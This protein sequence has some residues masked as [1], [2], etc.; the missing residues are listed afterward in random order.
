MTG[1]EEALP[2]YLT[3]H[4]TADLLRTTRKAIYVMIQRRQLPGITHIGRRVLLRSADV[5]EWLDQSRASSASETK[6]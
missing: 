3:P 1:R 5:L 2:M 6:R 4:E